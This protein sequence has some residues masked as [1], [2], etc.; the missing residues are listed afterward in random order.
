MSGKL[1]ILN[2][3]LGK[4]EKQ[5]AD[6]ARREKLTNCICG[7][8]I[9]AMSTDPEKFEAEMNRTCPAHGFRRF[10]KIIAVIFGSV[11]PADEPETDGQETDE[12]MAE[13]VAKNLAKLHQLLETYELRFW[14]DFKS[15][16]EREE[17]EEHE[18]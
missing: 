1:S 9:I 13:E 2:R 12:P 14:K 18:S 7:D 15:R 3:R 8:P 6:R 4:V 11:D 16:I 10:G 5:L 17:L